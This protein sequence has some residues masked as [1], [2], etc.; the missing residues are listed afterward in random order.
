MFRGIGR[1]NVGQAGP[2]HWIVALEGEHD[3]ST[4]ASLNDELEAIFRFGTTIIVDLSDVTFIDASVLSALLIAQRIVD[5]HEDE[6]LAVVAP[7]DGVALR[8]FRLTGTE[9]KFSIFETLTNALDVT[10]Q[11]DA[12]PG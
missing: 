7:H 8:L 1:I 12:T 10:R 6:H 5:N 9:E 3:L 4:V 11:L 2:T